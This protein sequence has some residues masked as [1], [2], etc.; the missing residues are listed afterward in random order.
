LAGKSKIVLKYRIEGDPNVSF[1]P[2]CCPTF[3]SIGPTLYFQQSG[4]DWNTDGK[5]WWATFEI[6]HPIQLGEFEI[7]VPLDGRWTSVEKMTAESNPNQFATAKQQA[8]RVGFTFGGG[9]GYGHGV[10]ANGSARFVLTSFKI[11]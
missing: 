5:R 2:A 9:D 10:Y 3:E 8:D 7:S 11:E 1:F 4:D 6:R